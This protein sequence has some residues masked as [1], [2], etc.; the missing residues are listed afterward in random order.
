MSGEFSG[1]VKKS[2]TRYI[3]DLHSAL[4]GLLDGRMRAFKNI[5]AKFSRRITGKEGT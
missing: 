3:L 5:T 1:V 4:M 2:L